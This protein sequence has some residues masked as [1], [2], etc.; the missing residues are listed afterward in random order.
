MNKDDPAKAGT[1]SLAA[2]EP[3]RIDGLLELVNHPLTWPATYLAESASLPALPLIFWLTEVFRPETVLTTGGTTRTAH[4]AFRQAADRL[5]LTTRCLDTGSAPDDTSDG[6]RAPQA[7]DATAQAGSIDILTVN[8]PQDSSRREQDISRI[9]AHAGRAGAILLYGPGLTESLI[10][11]VPAAGMKIMVFGRSAPQVALYL[12]PGAPSPL[13]QLAAL[14][15]DSAERRAFDD[16]LDRQGQMHRLDLMARG[17]GP[18]AAET[19]RDI[20]P[21]PSR[22]AEDVERLLAKLLELEETHSL[23]QHDR[24][25][26]DA[27]EPDLSAPQEPGEGPDLSDRLQDMEAEIAFLQQ[28]VLEGERDLKALRSSTSW[29]VTGPLRGVVRA[30]RR[31]RRR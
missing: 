12:A 2:A 5:C 22:H 14:P 10:A 18:R 29:R 21:P 24:P 27:G 26:A 6:A 4:R 20:A 11:G 30:L 25:E 28:R 16:F 17:A 7:D 9:A 31:F 3:P 1:G 23:A 8:L 19:V 15:P 13:S